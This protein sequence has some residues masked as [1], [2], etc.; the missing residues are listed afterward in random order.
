MTGKCRKSFCRTVHGTKSEATKALMEY[1]AESIDPSA[2]K[3]S[4]T[5]AGDH[6]VRF[7]EER[8]HE[9]RSP[10]ARNRETYESCG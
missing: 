7:H 9:L 8:E 6:F 3:P 4:D 1:H 10:L 5:T 2:I